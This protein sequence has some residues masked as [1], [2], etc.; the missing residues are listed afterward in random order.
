LSKNRFPTSTQRE[1]F[2]Y[3]VLKLRK[4]VLKYNLVNV[5]NVKKKWREKKDKLSSFNN[6]LISKH[7]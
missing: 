6:F 2:K 3:I 7:Y 1:I 5:L 4:F